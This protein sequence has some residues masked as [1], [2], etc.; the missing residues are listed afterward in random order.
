MMAAWSSSTLSRI[1]CVWKCSRCAPTACRAAAATGPRRP[2]RASRCRWRRRCA[3]ETRG[4]RRRASRNR[5]RASRMRVDRL[6]A[7]PPD[8]PAAAFARRARRSRLRSACARRA[9]RTD[10]GP[11]SA[12]PRLRGRRGSGVTK[13]PE[14]TRTSTRP[15]DL[16]RDD[17]FAHRRARHAEQRREL[18]LG[19][20]PRA[21]AG[22]R[23]CRSAPAICPAICRYRRS[24]STVC[25]GNGISSSRAGLCAGLP[26]VA[27]RSR[28]RRPRRASVV[29]EPRL[30]RR[31]ARRLVKWSNHRT[32][33]ATV[34]VPGIVA[35]APVNAGLRHDRA[36]KCPDL[37]PDFSSRRTPS[38]RMPRSAALHMS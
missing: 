10:S 27:G 29:C 26:R 31:A 36:A 4:R 21:G 38:M 16:E 30:V 37:P 14:P 8:R 25:S 19:R 9:A 2:A 20:Q 5:R 13:M 17:R 11:S 23:R 7:A 24:G 18:A 22:T 1:F 32:D 3:R 35:R 28:R 6:R 15:G 33:G 12:R 34:I